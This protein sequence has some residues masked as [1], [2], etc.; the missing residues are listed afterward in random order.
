MVASGSNVVVKALL[1]YYLLYV[2]TFVAA[3]VM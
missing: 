1:L 3:V 2:E